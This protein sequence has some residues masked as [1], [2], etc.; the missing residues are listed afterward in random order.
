MFQLK[1][2]PILMV[3]VSSFLE[4][5]CRAMLLAIF[6]IAFL[7]ALG[8]AVSAAFSTP[9]AAFVAVTYLLIGLAVR[10]AIDA[11]LQNDDGSYR[12]KGFHDKAAHYLAMGVGQVVVSVDDLDATSALANG[13][14]VE[15]S[16][17]LY[18]FFTLLLL[19]TGLISAVGLW[20]IYKRELG[21]VI[22]R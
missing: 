13:R 19:R 14:L 7:A 6:Q 9:V 1:D 22:R 21:A 18:S 17:L 10:P 20:I 16:R 15:N 5:Y 3:A 4:N 8:C 12:Y 2:G 11:P